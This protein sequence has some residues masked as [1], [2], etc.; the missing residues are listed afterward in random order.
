MI[1]QQSEFP[2]HHETTA[3]HH[4]SGIVLAAAVSRV[5]PQMAPSAHSCTRL[6]WSRSFEIARR[7][8]DVASSA[9]WGIAGSRGTNGAWAT[10][11]S[12]V[13]KLESKRSS[14]GR[15]VDFA[16][17]SANCKVRRSLSKKDTTSPK[18]KRH[19]TTRKSRIYP[20]VSTHTK[21]EMARLLRWLKTSSS[22]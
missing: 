15:R 3:A 1:S 18:S 8:R 17:N 11:K 4:L 10:K 12:S 9:Q 16:M 14:R 2:E 21:S 20:T 13:L 19:A 22:V 7:Q 5:G 6:K